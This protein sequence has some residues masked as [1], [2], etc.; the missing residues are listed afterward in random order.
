MAPEHGVLQWPQL[1]G[2]S[3]RFTHSVP[4]HEKPL[5]HVMELHVWGMP[6]S[7]AITPPA[8][9][10]PPVAMLPPDVAVPP[11]DARPPPPLAPL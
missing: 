6:A 10:A 1:R 9:L 11:P 8:P 2:S 5:L 4:Q 7:V 3:P